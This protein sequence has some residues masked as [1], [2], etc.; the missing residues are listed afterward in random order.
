MG[1]FG[2]IAGGLGL[3][4]GVA[5]SL[6]GDDGG[7]GAANAAAQQRTNQIES[8]YRQLLERRRGLFDEAFQVLQTRLDEFD[9]GFADAEAAISTGGVASKRAVLDNQKAAFGNLNAE[10]A[11]SGRLGDGLST[12]L[13]AGIAGQ[14]SR[15]LGE[16]DER[17]GGRL[18]QLLQ[19]RTLARSSL[20]GDIASFLGGRAESE[21]SFG[22]SRAGFYERDI[23]RILG[24]VGEGGDLSGLGFLGGGLLGGF[25]KDSDNPT[26][27]LDLFLGG[28]D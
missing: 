16:V 22:L 2:G 24:A 14:T 12:Q 9:A 13:K 4:G 26:G 3:I 1:L 11:G 21:T 23:E 19:R 25:G 10:L 8:I 18:G 17:I 28:D 20:S 27:L 15:A 6:F 5:G 7:A